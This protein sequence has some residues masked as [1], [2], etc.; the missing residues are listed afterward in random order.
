M[1]SLHSTLALTV[2]WQSSEILCSATTQ[3]AWDISVVV[4]AMVI[5]REQLDGQKTFTYH[6]V[7]FWHDKQ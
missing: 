7:S 4:C 1:G 5:S 3:T 2:V 6:S